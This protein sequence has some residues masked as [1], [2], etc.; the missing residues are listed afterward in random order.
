M[1]YEEDPSQE[2]VARSKALTGSTSRYFDQPKASRKTKNALSYKT[3]TTPDASVV[4]HPS[5]LDLLPEHATIKHDSDANFYSFRPTH[6]IFSDDGYET[7]RESP[8]VKHSRT[9]PLPKP[10]VDRY[11]EEVMQD[12]LEEHM[13]ANKSHDV[14]T[15]K[16]A[17]EN[18]EFD[19]EEMFGNIS[20]S[21]SPP[22]A[23][24]E[25]PKS[26]LNTKLSPPLK[27]PARLIIG[28]FG[29]PSIKR[30]RLHEDLPSSS[31][32]PARPSAQSENPHILCADENLPA[33][34]GRKLF[35]F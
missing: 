15:K 20:G 23:P 14:I 19:I 3:P 24:E 21:A 35:K 2:S 33:A 12:D 7:V 25:V 26:F 31:Y 34:Q 8:D 11:T 29:R 27:R 9:F 18:W 4:S 6:S 22:K 17:P 1:K 10:S 32:S 16:Q 5:I 28:S 13:E 30:Q